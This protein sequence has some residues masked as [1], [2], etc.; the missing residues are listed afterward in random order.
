MEEE[1]W[2]IL[3]CVLN[4]KREVGIVS[5]TLVYIP[6][7]NSRDR[8][9]YLVRVLTELRGRQDCMGIE[10]GSVVDRFI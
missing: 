1:Q 3:A 8:S 6:I 2:N 10:N 9:F 5:T 4:K 7:S